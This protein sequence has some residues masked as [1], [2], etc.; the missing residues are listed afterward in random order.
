MLYEFVWLTISRFLLSPLTN[1]SLPVW[2]SHSES[3][4]VIVSR[5]ESDVV[6]KHHSE[7]CWVTS[8]CFSPSQFTCPL[9]SYSSK[10]VIVS[11]G[12]SQWVMRSQTESCWVRV[13]LTRCD[14]SCFILNTFVVVFLGRTGS[15]WVM[16]SQDESG[17]VIMSRSESGWVIWNNVRKF[18]FWRWVILSH[19]ESFWVIL[20]HIELFWVIRSHSESFGCSP[21]MLSQ[22]TWVGFYIRVTSGSSFIRLCQV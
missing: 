15:L 13:A 21:I 22:P 3:G 9:F 14:W 10:Q 11:Q 18:T 4:W 5:A 12:E 2:V 16:V 17:W 8:L 1:W 7:S 20:S 6:T 19:S